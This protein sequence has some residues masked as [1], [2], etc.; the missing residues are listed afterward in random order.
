MAAQFTPISP[1]AMHTA[2]SEAACSADKIDVL[3]ARLIL[4]TDGAVRDFVDVV[5]SF[6]AALASA[7]ASFRSEAR[8]VT[9]LKMDGLDKY[10]EES[11][12][13]NEK[14]LLACA[15]LCSWDACAPEAVL[16]DASAVLGILDGVVTFPFSLM[17]GLSPAGPPRVSATLSTASRLQ[18]GISA[19]KSVLEGPGLQLCKAGGSDEAILQNAVRVVCRDE[20]GDSVKRLKTSDFEV[21]VC[22]GGVTGDVVSCWMEGDNVFGFTYSVPDD[23]VPTP[24]TVLVRVVDV[25]AWRGSPC[26]PRR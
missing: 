10:A 15:R 8:R 1:P 5:A 18:E 17:V 2:A 21:S 22:A 11:I 9:L 4:S 26:F 25:H 12:D 13:A 16:R 23:A 14:A 24:N 7:Q 20:F 6:K 19:S 3:A